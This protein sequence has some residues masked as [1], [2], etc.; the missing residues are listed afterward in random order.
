[1]LAYAIAGLSPQ[2]VQ[3]ITPNIHDK[4]S[5][6]LPSYAMKS[7]LSIIVMPIKKSTTFLIFHDIDTT[8][9][10]QAKMHYDAH[11]LGK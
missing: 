1:M 10:R 7:R 8:Q 4:I 6:P 11:I 9:L 2:S 3:Y 5:E